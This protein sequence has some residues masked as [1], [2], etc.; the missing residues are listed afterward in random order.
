VDENPTSNALL[1]GKA[2]RCLCPK[3]WSTGDL[4][5]KKIF[6]ALQSMILRGKAFS[7]EPVERSWSA[8]GARAAMLRLAQSAV[9]SGITLSRQMESW[10]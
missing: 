4:A 3:F 10:V 1:K 5:H 9:V 8:G 6:P 7:G 2:P